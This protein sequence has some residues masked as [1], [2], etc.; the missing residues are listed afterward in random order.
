MQPLDQIIFLP[1]R[2]SFLGEYQ[3]I[4]E[5]EEKELFTLSDREEEEPKADSDS[6]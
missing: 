6:L 3:L 5:V 2:V 4:E 1:P